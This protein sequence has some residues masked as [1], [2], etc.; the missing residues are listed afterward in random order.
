MREIKFRAWD[1]HKSEMSKSFELGGYPLF[2]NDR[3]ASYWPKMTTIMQFTGLKDK[4]G[5]EIYEGDIIITH[6]TKTTQYD[7]YTEKGVVVL[8]WNMFIGAK[9]EDQVHGKNN[10]IYSHSEIIGNIYEHPE[11]ISTNVKQL[12]PN[13]R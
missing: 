9:I 10:G 4:N 5:K 1:I 2:P 6:F 11:K 8:H 3:T 13:D 7:A 12:N